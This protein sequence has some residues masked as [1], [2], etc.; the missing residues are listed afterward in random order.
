MRTIVNMHELIYKARSAH[1]A[2]SIT[3]Y[4]FA[5][6]PAVAQCLPDPSYSYPFNQTSLGHVYLKWSPRLIL[7][8]MTN[9]RY[10]WLSN[11]GCFNTFV[12]YSQP[13]SALTPSLRQLPI[14]RTGSRQ[15]PPNYRLLNYTPRLS[16]ALWK[17]WL[18]RNWRLICKDR[19]S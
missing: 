16:S 2:Y 5:V 1:F 8:Q 19:L 7:N 9:P 11:Y 12:W 17:D 13:P 18:R 4:H 15:H 6:L 10:L 3:L 14:Y